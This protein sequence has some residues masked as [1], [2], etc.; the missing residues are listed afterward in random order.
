MYLSSG[1]MNRTSFNWLPV[2]SPLVSGTR[3]SSASKAEEDAYP[4]SVDLGGN[5]MP[6]ENERARESASLMMP[7]AGQGT[8]KSGWRGVSELAVKSSEGVG[9]AS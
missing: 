5:L 9:R 2:R 1:K 6:L 7:S 3:S 8:V 4:D